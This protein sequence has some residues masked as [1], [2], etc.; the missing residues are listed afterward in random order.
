MHLTAHRRSR[1]II[2]LFFIL[3]GLLIIARKSGMDIPRWIF[4]WEVLLIAIG[5]VIGIKHNFRQGGWMIVMLVG[6]VFLLDDIFPLSSFRP[7]FFP[8]VFV[9]IG[10]YMIFKPGGPGNRVSGDAGHPEDVGEDRLD[11]TAIFGSVKRNIISQK[12]RGGQVTSVFGESVIN[13]MQADIQGVAVLQTTQV[14]GSTKLMVPGNWEVR[15]EVT[16]I[17]GGVEDKRFNPAT[18]NSE[19]VLVIRGTALLGGLEINSF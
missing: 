18:T 3:A 10:L 2:G 5:L 6:L 8:A 12:F 1:R 7:Y 19:K 16:A 9:I 15:S 11:A 4:S 13:M 14:L 17:L